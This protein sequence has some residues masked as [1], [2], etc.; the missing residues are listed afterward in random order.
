[1]AFKFMK[2]R[3]TFSTRS[4]GCIT[5]PNRMGIGLMFAK[6]NT[7]YASVIG[8]SHEKTGSPCQDACRCRIIYTHDGQEIFLGIASDG[9]GSASRSEVASKL[10]VEMFLE[11]FSSLI[12]TENDICLIDR[13]VILDWLEE[14][15][16]QIFITAK[17][18]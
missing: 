2:R 11:K 1:M 10:A 14:V 5:S 3:F 18:E 15:K 4:N 13:N 9:A 17:N 16:T 6:W 12:K 8:T 7:A